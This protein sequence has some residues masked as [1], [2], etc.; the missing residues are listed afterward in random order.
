MPVLHY[1]KAMRRLINELS[2]LPSIGEKSAIRLAYHLISTENV[3]VELLAEAIKSSKT[4]ISYCEQCFFLSELK[5]CDICQ[6]KNRDKTKFCVVERPADVIA[7]EKSGGFEGLYHV[8]HG[9]WSPMQGISTDK[10]K[11]KELFDRIAIGSS[12]G[13]PVN[14]IV[15]ATGTTVE[16]DATALYLANSLEELGVNVT[17]IAQGMPKGGELEYADEVTLSHAFQGRRRIVG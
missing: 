14:E 13:E 6:D 2:K 5:L 12:I 3:N 7:I 17:R 10:I 9:L 1:P 15:L 8:L 4:Q 11:F 16:G